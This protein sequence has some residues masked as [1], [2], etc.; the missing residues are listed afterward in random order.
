M[1][2]GG[3]APRRVPETQNARS[4]RRLTTTT[5][6]HTTKPARPR[7]RSPLPRKPTT[8]PPPLPRTA[9]DGRH[10]PNNVTLDR[11]SPPSASPQTHSRPLL[12]VPGALCALLAAG[13][14]SAAMA[15]ARAR[16][17]SRGTTTK[18]RRSRRSNAL[19]HG[20]VLEF[21]RLVARLRRLAGGARPV[22]AAAGAVGRRPA[23][24]VPDGRRCPACSP[25]P[26]SECGCAGRCAHAGRPAL[27]AGRSRWGCVSPTR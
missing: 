6:D 26:R 22:R 12:H 21:L 24:G 13:A 5:S 20:H 16:T 14:A 18:T 9:D 8:Q 23:R 4:P 19:T 10:H 27:L 11:L 17:A 15:L 1:A 3:R 25:R 7:P 2:L